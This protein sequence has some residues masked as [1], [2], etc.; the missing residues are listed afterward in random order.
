[1]SVQR[2]T[3]TLHEHGFERIRGLPEALPEGERV[4][5]QGAPQWGSLAV[6]AFH[7]RKVLVYLLLLIGINAYAAWQ[8]SGVIGHVANTAVMPIAATAVCMALILGLAWV[9]SRTTVYTLTNKRMVLRV[10]MALP[11]TINLPFRLIRSA[12]FALHRDGTGDLP[13][14]LVP[15]ERIAYLMLWPHARRWSF[16]HPEPTLRSIAEPE[17]VAELLMY[18]VADQGSARVRTVKAEPLEGTIATA[19]A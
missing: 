16:R 19:A 14:E 13:L 18:A 3:P 17:K 2:L 4:I 6:H 15:G 8:E 1:M 10:G 12:A 5:W 7:V 11:V 9:S